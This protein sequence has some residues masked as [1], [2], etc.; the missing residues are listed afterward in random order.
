M[1]RRL[2]HAGRF[3]FAPRRRGLILHDCICSFVSWGLHG[4]P[5]ATLAHLCTDNRVAWHG[6]CIIARMRPQYLYRGLDYVVTLLHLQ[7]PAALQA[8]SVYVLESPDV[9]GTALCRCMR[10]ETGTHPVEACHRICP[11]QEDAA[12]CR[13]LPHTATCCRAC[14][15]PPLQTSGSRLSHPCRLPAIQDPS[16]RPHCT[17]L[18]PWTR[19]R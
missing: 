10:Q 15:M 7:G 9:P 12:P 13:I 6:F 4:M 14:I 1:G 8:L 5:A 2:Y 17:L 16:S 11:V 18:L 19:H 3:G